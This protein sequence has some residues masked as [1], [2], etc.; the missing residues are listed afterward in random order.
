M[1]I[2]VNPTQFA[3]GEDF[4]V[5]PRH[6]PACTP[7]TRCFAH[8]QASTLAAAVV[9][10]FPP[11]APLPPVQRNTRDPD[12]DHSKL[13]SVSADAVFEPT[14]LYVTPG[15]ADPPHETFVTVERLQLPLCGKSRPTHFRGV[16]TVVAKL[17]N[18]VQPDLAARRPP[19]IPSP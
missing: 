16:S 14:D 4:D 17:F 19:D 13:L 10:L 6:P 9:T 7:R 12:G 8:R 18:I 5:Y 15:P 1:S 3:P 11:F 2:Y